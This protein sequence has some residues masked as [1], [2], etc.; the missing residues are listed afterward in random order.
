M[1]KKGGNA[2]MGTVLR[3]SIINISIIC[4]IINISIICNINI[5]IICKINQR[6]GFYRIILLN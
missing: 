1:A 6:T 3:D 2:R 4:N 5:S